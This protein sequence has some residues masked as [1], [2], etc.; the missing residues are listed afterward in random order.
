MVK[1]L[2][3]TLCAATRQE[4]GCNRYDGHI[5]LDEPNKFVFVESWQSREAFAEHLKQ[6]YVAE[7]RAASSGHV[8]AR[9]VEIIYVDRVERP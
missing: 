5:S 3:K 9:E 2:L 8:L 6:P 4:N 1:T 7:W